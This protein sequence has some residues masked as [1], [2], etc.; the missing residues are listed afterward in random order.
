MIHK[1]TMFIGL[2][3]KDTKIQEI[4]TL[5]AYKIVARAI[6]VDSTITEARGV[7]THRDGTVVLE[8]SLVIE[9]LDFDNTYDKIWVKDKVKQIKTLLNQESVAI[10]HEQIDSSLI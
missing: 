3:D 7:Y 1:I 2:N 6:G 9:I 5:D 8:T 10:Q 4:N